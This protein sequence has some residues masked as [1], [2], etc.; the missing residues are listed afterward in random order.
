MGVVY[1]SLRNLDHEDN[2]FEPEFRQRFDPGTLEGHGITM[3]KLETICGSVPEEP[4]ILKVVREMKKRRK[5]APQP[6][7]EPDDD[8][9]KRQE[10]D[11]IVRRARAQAPLRRNE[12]RNRGYDVK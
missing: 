12:L 4:E 2:P 1:W 3:E 10:R 8:E 9:I 5:S 6:A 7:R 11:D